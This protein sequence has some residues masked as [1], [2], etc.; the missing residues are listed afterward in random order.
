[1][2]PKVAWKPKPVLEPKAAWSV[3]ESERL[4]EPKVWPVEGSEFGP[5]LATAWIVIKSKF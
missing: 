3:V 1:M 2:E 5:E 4:S